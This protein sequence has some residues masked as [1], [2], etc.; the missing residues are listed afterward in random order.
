MR[1]FPFEFKDSGAKVLCKKV[2]PFIASEARTAAQRGK[3][4]PPTRVIDE[5]GPL[6]GQ[7]EE[8][9]TPDHVEA[10]RQWGRKA[11][12]LLMQMQIRRAIKKVLE[13]EDWQDQVTEYRMERYEMT[14]ALKTLNPDYEPDPLP[15]DD[16][17]VF[18]LFIAAATAEDLNEFVK[19]ISTRSYP[20]PE[21]VAAAQ[22]S[23]QPDLQK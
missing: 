6:Q 16:L 22:D 3:P 8:M 10:V 9:I 15:E 4:K 21:V 1:E 20:S 17:T 5:P 11:D 19:E 18:V 7:T 2:S 23:F 13:P 12:E 14:L